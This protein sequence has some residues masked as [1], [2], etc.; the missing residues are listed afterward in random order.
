MRYTTAG[1]E[2]RHVRALVQI[3]WRTQAPV[4]VSMEVDVGTFG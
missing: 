3:P 2:A 1:D 4:G